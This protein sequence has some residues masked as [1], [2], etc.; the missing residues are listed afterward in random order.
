VPLF[1]IKRSQNRDLSPLGALQQSP[2][3]VLP[4]IDV[5]C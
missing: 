3:P 5:R 4:C 1:E 2:P